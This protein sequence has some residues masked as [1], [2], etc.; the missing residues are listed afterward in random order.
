MKRLVCLSIA[1]TMTACSS[2]TN[3]LV[4]DPEARIFVN[5]EYIGTGKARYSDLKPAFTKQEITIRKDGCA[6]QDYVMRRN[7]RPHLG[8][9]VSAYWLY[10][11]ILWMTK[12][13]P[14][15]AYEFDCVPAAA[16]AAPD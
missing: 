8:A 9:I 14:R 6:E 2:G 1:A 10:L 3:I 13:K 4:S 11:P 12:Y 15:H 7:E 16:A 5:G